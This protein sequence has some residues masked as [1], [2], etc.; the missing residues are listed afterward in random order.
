MVIWVLGLILF[1]SGNHSNIA[2]FVPLVNAARKKSTLV[3]DDNEI[4]ILYL[5]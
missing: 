2:D 3:L 1:T 5:R 4:L